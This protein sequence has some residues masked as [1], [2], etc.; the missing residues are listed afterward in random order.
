MEARNRIEGRDK[1]NKGEEGGKEKKKA[2]ETID[3]ETNEYTNSPRKKMGWGGSANPMD[4]ETR[5]DNT[6][7]QEADGDVE[8]T[9]SE[10]GTEDHDL[11]DIVEREWI[12]LLN[13]L[14]KWKRQGVDNVPTEKLERI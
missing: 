9:P 1:S 10:V 6:P 3:Q 4:R 11:R 13:I 7:M 8:M 14:E 5:D 2:K 12:D